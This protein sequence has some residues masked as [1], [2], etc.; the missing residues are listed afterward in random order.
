MASSIRAPVREYKCAR[1]TE[2]LRMI[3]D[4]AYGPTGNVIVTPDVE[5]EPFGTLSVNV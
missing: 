1:A 3:S 2:I 5:V 4:D